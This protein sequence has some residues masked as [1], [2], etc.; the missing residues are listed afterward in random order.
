MPRLIYEVDIT[1]PDVRVETGLRL[2]RDNLTDHLTQGL[3]AE[4]A[5]K[6]EAGEISHSNLPWLLV[7]PS[8]SWSDR[9]YLASYSPSHAYPLP[10]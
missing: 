3:P 8:P 5:D 4:I 10:W 2:L 1:S 6:L 7:S 9:A